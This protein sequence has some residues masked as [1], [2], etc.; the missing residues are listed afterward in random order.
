MV[1]R[2]IDVEKAAGSNPASRTMIFLYFFI[3]CIFLVILIIF[4]LFFIL[5]IIAAFT[6]DAPFVSIPD[7]IEDE[8]IRNLKLDSV[9]NSPTVLYDL[10]CGDARI[11][12]KAVWK[13]PNIKAVGIEKA[14]IPYLLAKFY[15]RNLHNIDIRR[16][17][18]FT[19]DI[20]NATH[21]FVYL[22]PHI[23]TKLMPKIEKECRPGTR[24][25]SCDFECTDRTPAEII[26]LSPSL[27]TQKVTRGK[28]LFVY[29]T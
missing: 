18:I 20:S 24:I 25:V 2:L 10:G 7:G 6:T 15:T 11:L 21:I 22:Y 3:I 14:Y 29:V 17:D 23:V 19:A 8:I 9:G 1:E 28:K 12:I 26:P 13:H 16:E 5:E 4:I 27:Q